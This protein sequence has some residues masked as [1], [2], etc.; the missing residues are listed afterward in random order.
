VLKTCNE[1]A[2]GIDKLNGTMNNFMNKLLGQ[3]EEGPTIV[4]LL[5]ITPI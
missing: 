2:R 3:L 1:I 5:T 4:K